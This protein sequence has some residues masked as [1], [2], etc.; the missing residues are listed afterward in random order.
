MKVLLVQCPCGFGNATPPLGLAYLSAFIKKNNH[1]AEVKDLSIELF[2]QVY[3]DSK[4]LWHTNNGYRWYLIESFY[5]LPFLNEKLYED[6]SDQILASDADVLGFS[7]QSTSALFTLELIRRIKAKAPSRK[8]IL[9]GSNCYNISGDSSSFR[10]N[11]S[12]E[13]FADVIVVG[14]GE[15]TL[16]NVLELL[17]AGNALDNCKGIAVPRNGKWAFNGF[18]DTKLD[19]NELPFPDFDAFNLNLYTAKN[20]L[21]LQTSRGCV[22]RCVFCTDTNFWRPYRFTRSEN[23]LKTL[24]EMKARYDTKIVDLNDSLMNGNSK[25]LEALCDRII[26]NKLEIAWGGNC[27]IDKTMSDSVFKKMKC[28]GCNYVLLGIESASDKILKLMKKGFDS[29]DAQNFIAACFRNDIHVTA[30]WIVGFPGETEGDF[31]ATVNFIKKNRLYIKRNTFSALAINQFSYLDEHRDEFGV[32]LDG[33]HL[34][35]WYSADG[36]NT[37]EL[38][39]SRLKRLEEN[40]AEWHR[41]YLITRQAIA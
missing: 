24:L 4:E 30:N 22:M 37:I 18:P 34:G 21:P 8:I 9:G 1:Q 19:L 33:P 5:K 35:R 2:C 3:P 29:K 41:D 15:Q 20:T 17:G 6:F 26:E 39:S 16:L 27:R 11:Y 32:V 25:N 14:E 7:I 12:L 38:R 10:L 28:A 23:V 40:E 36:Q 13:Q 31:M